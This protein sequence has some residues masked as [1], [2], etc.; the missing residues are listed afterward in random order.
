MIPSNTI[1]PSIGSGKKSC[2]KQMWYNLTS[3][4]NTIRSLQVNEKNF[5]CQ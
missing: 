5:N 4:L 3:K 1:S 2:F